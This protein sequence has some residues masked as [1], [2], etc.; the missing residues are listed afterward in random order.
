MCLLAA[1]FE[2]SLVCYGAAM[3]GKMVCMYILD[4]YDVAVAKNG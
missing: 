1:Q 4:T 2:R 3:K